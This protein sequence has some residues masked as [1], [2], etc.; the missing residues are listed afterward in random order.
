MEAWAAL[1]TAIAALTAALVWPVAIFAFVYLFKGKMS[2]ALDK[3]PSILERA[4]KIKLGWL[5]LELDKQAESISGDIHGGEQISAQQI[6]AA[7]RVEV[8]AK[9]LD[10]Q[11]L[12]DKI[13]QLCFEYETVRKVLPSGSERTRA[14]TQTFVKMRTLGPAVADWIEEMKASA[15]AGNRLLAIAI[16]QI[17]PDK[18][19]IDW[20]V[21][22]FETEKPFVFFHAANALRI[23]A[24]SSFSTR[25]N[26]ARAA[27]E[28]A[29]ERINGFQGPRD[30]DTIRVLSAIVQAG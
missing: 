26:A 19:D 7:A 9:S 22:R 30:S 16:M 1:I 15:V 13:Q 11:S 8:Q 5:D 4:N 21:E 3:L 12:R 2:V 20:L 25:A 23:V 6:Q 17:D 18:A 28:Q 27:A 10:L 14:M 29:L 24:T